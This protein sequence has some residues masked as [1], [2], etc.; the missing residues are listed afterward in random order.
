MLE[1]TASRREIIDTVLAVFP[2]SARRKEN[3]CDLRNNWLEAWGNE[4]ADQRL[5]KD[6][7][8]GFLYYRWRIEVT[9]TTNN[10]STD[11]QITLA[12]LLQQCFEKSGWVAV[13]CAD[14]ED[15]L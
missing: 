12:R 8:E 14:F 2:E 5:A 1:A 9:P 13:V 15:R 7:E 3:S 4:D 6:D 10:P 11:E